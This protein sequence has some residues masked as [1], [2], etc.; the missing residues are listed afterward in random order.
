MTASLFSVCLQN[1]NRWRT[2]VCSTVK[3]RAVNK[4]RFPAA[5]PPTG[6]CLSR[7]TSR[8]QSNTNQ[9]SFIQLL[10]CVCSIPAAKE[11]SFRVKRT[12]FRSVQIIWFK[13]MLKSSSD[14]GATRTLTPDQRIQVRYGSAGLRRSLDPLRTRQE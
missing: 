2:G 13:K 8:R 10:K 9:S 4:Q 6:V 3:L 14:S 7:R 5:F 11:I 1:P 12:Q